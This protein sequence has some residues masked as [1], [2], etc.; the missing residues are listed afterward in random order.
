MSARPLQRSKVKRRM[1]RKKPIRNLVQSYQPG[2][3][4]IHEYCKRHGFTV[5]SFY[6]WR[7]RIHQQEISSFVTIQP[8][9]EKVQTIHLR[10]PSGIEIHL[11]DLCKG[12]IIEW[13]LELEQAYAEL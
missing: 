13:T 1:K 3:L 2:D 5:A 7:K 6:Y 10:L 4:S 12:E 8:V 11:P 9:I